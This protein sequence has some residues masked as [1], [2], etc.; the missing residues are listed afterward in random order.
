ML[1]VEAWLRATG[2]VA[3]PAEE[4]GLTMLR[5]IQIGFLLLIVALAAPAGADDV[6]VTLDAADGFVIENNAGTIERLRI[7]EATGNISRN[8]VLFV[9]TTGT[10]NTFV[11]AGAGNPATSGVGSNAAFGEDAL[12]ANTTGNRNSAFGDAA[13]RSNTTGSRN[14]A[15]GETALRPRCRISFWAHSR[16][17]RNNSGLI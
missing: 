14:A 2:V 9:H 10:D 5:T 4:R 12:G 8:G 17:K 13:L 11:G 7:D 16:S 1:R 3:G 15:F 6:T